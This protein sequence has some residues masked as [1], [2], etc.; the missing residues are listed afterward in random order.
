[1]LFQIFCGFSFLAPNTALVYNMHMSKIHVSP[2]AGNSLIKYA[3]ECGHDVCFFTP[4][5]NV[6][7]SISCHPDLLL[8]KLYPGGKVFHGDPDLLRPGYPEETIFN[9]CSTGRYFIHNL[10]HTERSLLDAAR[11]SGLHMINVRQGY[12]KCSIV[13]VDESS[14]ITYDDGIADACT[15]AGIDVLKVSPGNVVLPGYNTG[16]IGGA[17]GKIGS[18]VVFNGDLSRH[19]DFL[20]IVDYIKSRGLDCV[21]FDDYPLTDIGSV[22]EEKSEGKI[23]GIF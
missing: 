10:N 9:A 5:N 3:K 22:I 13:E 8:C 2:Q 19:P 6:S 20:R 12:A 16:F 17:S 4:L 11:D 18:S 7:K 1:M 23:Q 21:Y 14:I 15:K